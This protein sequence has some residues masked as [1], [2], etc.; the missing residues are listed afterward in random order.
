MNKER[1]KVNINAYLVLEQEGKILLALRQNTGY[2]DGQYSLVAG[3]VEA[4]ESATVAMCREAKKGIG[5][6]IE[7]EEL[8]VVLTMHRRTD[9]DNIDLFMRCSFWHNDIVNN[10][11][12]KCGA[13]AFFDYDSIPKNTIPYIIRA[14][15]DIRKGI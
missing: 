3:H 14:L 15:L 8:E 12:A 10:E 2:Q 7:C 5:I 1:S 4:G 9:R 11:P 13:L 6:D